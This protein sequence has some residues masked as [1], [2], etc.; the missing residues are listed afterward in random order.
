MSVGGEQGHDPLHD[1]EVTEMGQSSPTERDSTW[2]CWSMF[3]RGMSAWRV[4]RD[5][6]FGVG[7]QGMRVNKP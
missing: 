7:Y 6:A 4:L 2:R 5:S 1:G 3:L